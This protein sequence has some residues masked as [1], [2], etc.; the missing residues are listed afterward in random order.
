MVLSEPI[1]IEHPTLVV[2][3]MKTEIFT[4]GA[5]EAI[6]ARFGA[7][8]RYGDNERELVVVSRNN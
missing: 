1:L 5:A 7:L 6:R 3:I 8:L 2:N 4:D